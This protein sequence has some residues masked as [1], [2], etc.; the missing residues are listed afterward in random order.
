MFSG[1]DEWPLQKDMYIL[2]DGIWGWG[3]KEEIQVS[4]E[5]SSDLSDP[6]PKVHAYVDKPFPP[7]TQNFSLLVFSEP[8]PQASE[9]F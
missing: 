7:C 3:R 8:H 5:S 9:G 2:T 6:H 4:P 1:E